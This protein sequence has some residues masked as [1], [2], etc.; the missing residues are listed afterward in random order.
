MTY[1]AHPAEAYKDDTTVHA[2]TWVLALV[3]LFTASIGTWM[4]F[5]EEGSTITIN[6]RTWTIEEIPEF[7]APLLL[8]AGGA[9]ACIAMAVAA[10]R[11]VQHSG[12]RWLTAAEILI[13]LIGLAAVVGGIALIV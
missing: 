11:D 12:S 7:W 10:T 9:V 5:A 6:T 2:V 13:A 4:G 1:T 3:G 8:I